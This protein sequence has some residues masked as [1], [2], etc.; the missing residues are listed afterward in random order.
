MALALLVSLPFRMI[1]CYRIVRVLTLAVSVPT[2]VTAFAGPPIPPSPLPAPTGTVVNVSSV[3]Q[4]QSERRTT[5]RAASCATTSSIADPV[6]RANTAIYVAD[7]PGTQV[8]HNSIL[9]SRTYPSPIEYRF[10]HTTGVVVLNNVLDGNILARDGAAATVAGNHTSADASLFVNPTA[11][12]LHVKPTAT[13]L[14]NKVATP[15]SAA[16]LDWDG[17]PRPA[18][19]SEIG[20]DESVAAPS[21]PTNL[22]ITR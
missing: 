7:S 9:V 15:P 20:A 14:L 22:R 12:D 1:N 2:G 18:G 6:W 3:S 13:A 11:G 16:G 21:A 4:L 10:P 8:L 17:Q 5:T 19:S